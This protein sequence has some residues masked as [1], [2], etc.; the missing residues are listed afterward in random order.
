M[1]RAE[2]DEIKSIVKDEMVNAVKLK[3][4]L[5]IDIG[6]GENWLEAH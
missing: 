6:I 1:Y 4:P 5:V 3:V 2:S